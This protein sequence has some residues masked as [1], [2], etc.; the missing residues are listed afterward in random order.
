MH[1]IIKDLNWRYATKK[2]DTSKKVTDEDIDIIKESLRLVPTSY[3]LQPLKF[4]FVE[5]PSTRKLLKDASYGQTQVEDASHLIV[6]CAFEELNDAHVDTHISNI[7][8]TRKLESEKLKGY[9]DFMKKSIAG[10][11]KEEKVIW[12]SKQAY[13]ALG[14]LLHTCASLKIDTTPMEG[15]DAIQ[16]NEILELQKD[17]LTA[18]LACPIGYRHKD[19]PIQFEQKV[20]KNQNE[21]FIYK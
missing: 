21:L 5:S 14:Q 15:F 2:F 9:S 13:I 19:D 1:S 18:V 7:V 8:E 12:N 11:S 10:L 16:Y 6:I 17:N 20:R 4:V 3:G